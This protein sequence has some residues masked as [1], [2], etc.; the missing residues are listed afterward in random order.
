MSSCISSFISY[1]C[2]GFPSTENN[3]DNEAQPVSISRS[4][5]SFCTRLWNRVHIVQCGSLTGT[6]CTLGMSAISAAIAYLT[7]SSQPTTFVLSATVGGI[8]L[9]ASASQICA[10]FYL[11]AWKPQKN[12][13][14]NIHLLGQLNQ[15]TNS[16]LVHIN[17][18]VQQLQTDN[19]NLKKLLADEKELSNTRSNDIKVK[20]QTIENL[21][22][23]IKEIT[24]SLSI[25]QSLVTNWQEA[26][27][28]ITQVVK[29]ISPEKLQSNISDLSLKLSGL[30]QAATAFD[31][32]NENLEEV[33]IS[34]ENEKNTLSLL[35]S[36][37]K[38]AY[39]SLISDAKEK[40]S[41][42]EEANAVIQQL[43]KNV[44]GL[45]EEN[46]KLQI[47]AQQTRELQG[48]CDLLYKKL[49]E[50]SPE[51]ANLLNK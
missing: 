29:E 31:K 26:A 39:N 20:S 25:S 38:T 32:Q 37:L 44:S 2:A 43:E 35:T 49:L 3:S 47:V 16:Q 1:C 17:T 51:I 6:I 8:S 45:H 28:Q 24:K 48:K 41:L 11:C 42:L 5:E 27:H 36:Q 4:P 30:D 23:Q 12:F 14:E 50:I 21:T 7:Y 10:L 15:N 46:A 13:E 33:A 19:A 9:C 22:L 18:Q 40:K 34:I